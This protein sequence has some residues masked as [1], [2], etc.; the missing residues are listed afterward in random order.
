M[1]EAYKKWLSDFADNQRGSG[2]ISAIVPSCGWGYNWGSG[3]AWDF[4]LF[5]LTRALDFYYE[6]HDFARE[7]FPVLEK[8]LRYAKTYEKDG[9]VCYGLGDWNYPKNVSFAVCRPN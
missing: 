1:R 4:A 5:Q 2:Q 7:M 9:L 3:P 6:E 8:Y